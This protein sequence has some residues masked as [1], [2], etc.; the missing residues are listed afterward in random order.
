MRCNVHGVNFDEGWYIE[1]RSLLQ[2][3]VYC[4]WEGLGGGLVY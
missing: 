1:A 3:F 2:N 4:T